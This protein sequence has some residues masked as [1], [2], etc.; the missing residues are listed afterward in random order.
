[1]CF[2]EAENKE[3]SLWLSEMTKSKLD[4]RSFKFPGGENSDDV[5]ERAAAFVDKEILTKMG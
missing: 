4:P 1:M 5:K 3:G 2:G